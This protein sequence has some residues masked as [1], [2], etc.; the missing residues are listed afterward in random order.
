MTAA[1]AADSG[2]DS[3]SESAARQ[4]AEKAL[5]L[6]VAN[7]L[8]VAG[9]GADPARVAAVMAGLAPQAE[10]AGGRSLRA[11]FRRAAR[12]GLRS[13][14]AI[15]QGLTG[16]LP[17]PDMLKR[18]SLMRGETDLVAAEEMLRDRQSFPKATALILGNMA[19]QGKLAAVA[20]TFDMLRRYDPDSGLAL[21]MVNAIWDGALGISRTATA[22]RP[23]ATPQFHVTEW[24]ED[25]VPE[26]VEASG[27]AIPPYL[28][29]A[30]SQYAARRRRLPHL[31][32][33]LLV[34]LD[35][36]DH[37]S[38]R[39]KA[40]RNIRN[41]LAYEFQEDTASLNRV[42]FQCALVFQTPERLLAYLQ[43][44]GQDF[45]DPMRRLLRDLDPP[46]LAHIDH[47][48]WGDALIAQG[49][50][51]AFLMGYAQRVPGPLPMSGPDG[52]ISLRLTREKVANYSY[53]RRAESPE[54][55][56]ICFD[57]HADEK[58]FNRALHVLRTTRALRVPSPP[59]K[60]TIPDL[61]LRGPEFGMGDDVTFRRLDWDDKRMLMV[62]GYSKCCEKIGGL[63]EAT[64]F[65]ALQTRKSGFY[66]IERNGR[67]IGHS[68]A[69]RG[70]RGTLV[71]DGFESADPTVTSD[72]LNGLLRRVCD[73]LHDPF[74]ERYRIARVVLGQS[75]A[76]LRPQGDIPALPDNDEIERLMSRDLMG[77]KEIFNT[78]GY[79]GNAAEQFLIGTVKYYPSWY[80]IDRPRL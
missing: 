75:A 2:H 70:D 71:I 35:G 46:L 42:A 1:S 57:V 9:V 52:R 17:A 19:A 63:Y 54:L 40:Y 6:G 78:F 64:I 22:Q 4:A 15:F 34:G 38:V 45:S 67:I 59:H 5:A 11:G 69:W 77:E 76:H 25:T 41:I 53:L 60:E 28:I 30:Y 56:D 31:E 49:P 65:H 79:L 20:K 13:Y 3:R 66:V 10:D 48:L 7:D 16:G 39:A 12:P 21:Q 68:W 27:V 18:A 26:L 80:Y 43:R 73:T 36:M 23:C 44:W 51:M 47:A 55:A 8:R 62:G 24:L 58:A 37:L 61:S 29:S 32:G 72:R 33:A 14:L 50:E 74:Y